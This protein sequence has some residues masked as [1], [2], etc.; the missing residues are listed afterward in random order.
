M[1]RNFCTQSTLW[2]LLLLL[3]LLRHSVFICTTGHKCIWCSTIQY[4]TIC[5]YNENALEFY[6]PTNINSNRILNDL[7]WYFTFWTY[8]LCFDLC[9]FTFHMNFIPC[10]NNLHF[11]PFMT[12]EIYRISWDL[13][14]RPTLISFS[15][16]LNHEN[17]PKWKLKMGKKRNTCYTMTV[18]RCPA[19]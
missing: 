4:P 15:M 9:L 12:V 2:L 16:T 1:G 18:K 13:D 10:I 11:F 3:L 19:K 17:L 8:S 14:N 6:T 5:L 7:S